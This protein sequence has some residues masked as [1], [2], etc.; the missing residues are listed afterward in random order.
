MPVLLTKLLHLARLSR[1]AMLITAVSNGWMIVFLTRSGLDK[2]E[3]HGLVEQ[4]PLWVVLPLVAIAAAGLHT[5]AVV[6]NDVVDARHDRLFSPHRPIA[7]GRVGIVGGVVIAVTSL[8]AAIGASVVLGTGPAILCLVASAGVLFYDTAGK[9]LPALGILGVCVV[10]ALNGFLPN[11]TVGYVWPIGLVFSHVMFALVVSHNL[12][13]KR[14]RLRERDILA[15]IGAWAFTA[16]VLMSWMSW[17]HT[18]SLS[19]QAA[20]WVGPTAAGGVYLIIAQRWI[21]KLRQPRHHRRMATDLFLGFSMLWLIVYDAAWLFG[22][23]LGWQGLGQTALLVL[24][25]VTLAGE[26]P[27]NHLLIQTPSYEAGDRHPKA[28]PANTK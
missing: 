23:G 18:L 15:L 11:P 19:G 9:F 25:G 27:S 8:L 21:K 4:G 28:H 14:P 1:A 10:R 22:M 2:G 13:G 17:R 12:A 26:Y 24:G 3:A 20:A 7:S 5:Y 6:L 16:L